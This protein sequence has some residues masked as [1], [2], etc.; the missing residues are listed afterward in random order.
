MDAQ[1]LCGAFQ[2]GGDSGGGAGGIGGGVLLIQLDFAVLDG[3][4]GNGFGGG[5]QN[6]AGDIAVFIL[7]HNAVVSNLSK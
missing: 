3:G 1:L 5:G 7:Y 2:V 4:A 6:V